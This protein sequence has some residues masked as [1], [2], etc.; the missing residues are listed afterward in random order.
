[1]YRDIFHT[2][3]VWDIFESRNSKV[4]PR[5]LGVRPPARHAAWNSLA[6]CST[7]RTGEEGREENGQSPTPEQSS[8][9]GGGFKYLMTLCI[10]FLSFIHCGGFIY[11]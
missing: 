2:W 6:T 4:I 9:E 10:D 8:G 5:V 1:M 11:F 3:S 7:L